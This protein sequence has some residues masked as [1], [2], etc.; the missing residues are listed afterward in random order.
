M[1]SNL[2]LI[3]INIF[4]TFFLLEFI[5]S[6]FFQDKLQKIFPEYLNEPKTFGRGYPLGHFV[7]D[8]LKG[9]DIKK[10][11]NKVLSYLPPETPP[12]PVWGNNIGC[13]DYE[14]NKNSKY[15]I[16]LAGDSHTWGYAPIEKKF[17]TLLEEQYKLNVAGC[18]VSHTGQKHQ[19]QKFKEI[20]KSLGYIP[21]YV[22]VNRDFNDID[23]D[24]FHPHSTIIDGYQIDDIRLLVS[25]SSISFEKKKY[26][27]MKEYLDFKVSQRSNYPLGRFDPRKYS[28]SAIILIDMLYKPLKNIIYDKKSKCSV[29]NTGIYYF[30]NCFPQKVLKYDLDSEIIKPNKSAI[31]EWIKHSKENNYKLIFSDANLSNFL[32]KV[33]G[34]EKFSRNFCNFIKNNG[35][36]CFEFRDYIKNNNIDFKKTLWKKD[37]HYN[38]YGNKLYANYLVEILKNNR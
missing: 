37:G 26:Q 14:I 20:I 31:L 18:G 33:N 17:G 12:Y 7:A 19:F 15:D 10:N 3:G 24:Y 6:I 27:E 25:E 30:S 1:K 13:F 35:I 21:K 36:G 8:N 38:F 4:V 16:Y 34:E 2:K 32:L 29:K 11:S 22:I 5:S 23:N 9:F 28:S